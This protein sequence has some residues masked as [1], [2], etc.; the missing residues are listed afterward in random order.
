MA[1][2]NKAKFASKSR[3]SALRIEALEQRQLLAAVTGGGTEVGTDIRHPNGNIYDQVLM[4]G[5]SVTVSADAGQ[6]TRVSFLDLSGDIVQAEFSGKGSLTISLDQFKAAAEAANYNQPGVKYV[7]GL[8]TF[9]IQGEDASTNFSVFSVGSG[10]AVNQDLFAGGKTGGNHIADVARLLIVQDA[11]SPGG[12]SMGGIRAG[13]AIFAD[14]S[15]AVG[16][17]AANVHTQGPVI[18]GDVDASNAGVPTLKFGGNSQ[19]ATLQVAGGDLVQT[20]GQTFAGN[21]AGFTAINSTA[22]TDSSGTTLGSK[23]ISGSQGAGA[24]A[25]LGLNVVTLETLTTYDLTGKTQADLNAAFNGRTF[26]NDVTITG[27]LSGVNNIA[28]AEFRG[29]LTF[30]GVLTGNVTVTGAVKSLTLN[31][32]ASSSEV[33]K[34]G[35]IGN[36]TTAGTASLANTINANSIGDVTVGGALT[37]TVSTDTDTVAGFSGTESK[38]GNV[39]VTGN[40]NGTV[41]GVLGIGNVTV[42][43]EVN[44][45]GTT[46]QTSSGASGDAFLGSI[47]TI[48]INGDNRGGG[49]LINIIGNGTFGDVTIKGGGTDTAAHVTGSIT[50]GGKLG[51]DGTKTGNISVTDNTNATTTLTL[52]AISLT[53]TAANGSLGTISVTNTVGNAATSAIG[54]AGTGSI[55]DLTVTSS[56]AKSSTAAIGAITL[57][58]GTGGVT[59]SSLTVSNAETITIGAITGKNVGAIKATAVNV[60]GVAPSITLGA[61]TASNSNSATIGNITLDATTA[62]TSSVTIGG[63]IAT[64]NTASGASS[65]IGTVTI[66]GAAINI[67]N[68]LQAK[69]IGAVTLNGATVFAANKGF[70]ALGGLASLTVNGSTTFGTNVTVAT[71]TPNG[72]NA[73]FTGVDSATPNIWVGGTSG[74]FTFN[75]KTTFGAATGATGNVPTILGDNLGSARDVLGNLTFNGL[76]VGGTGIE[77]RAS[78]IGNVTVSSALN[79]GES[80]VTNFDVYAGNNQAGGLVGHISDTDPTRQLVPSTT[81]SQA[82]T[83]AR[84]GSNLANYSIGNITVSSTNTIGVTNTAL[85]SGSNTFAA[86]GKIG[87]VSLAGGGSAAVQTALFDSGTNGA[88]GALFQTGNGNVVATGANT[89]TLAKT[90]SGIDFDGNG[91]IGT[92]FASNTDTNINGS[93]ETASTFSTNVAVSI[94]N[95][96]VNAAALSGTNDSLWRAGGAASGTDGLVVLSAVKGA[97]YAPASLA[98]INSTLKGTVGNTTLTNLN[99]QL[100][101]R[102]TNGGPVKAADATTD[103][104]TSNLAGV[105]AAAGDAT[106]NSP[107]G[108]L[109][110]STVTSTLTASKNGFLVGGTQADPTLPAGATADG[111]SIIV[112]RL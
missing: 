97:N 88:P 29:A 111:N 76:V 71:S 100:S 61:V 91:V 43:G 106:T 108:T 99:Q 57:G 104:L 11:S 69:A 2:R 103:I 59:L 110:G 92:V 45:T 66:T 70:K 38:I 56:G 93:E 107:F 68:S 50:V 20:N 23:V 9:T 47:G 26:T 109:Q 105:I 102:P 1:K 18:I 55:G 19:F 58:T 33:F 82:E 112:I 31:S 35:T 36:V 5:A 62:T 17:S 12:S 64:N 53:S 8:A 77:V 73:A 44:T 46:L 94:G 63:N 49:K 30:T 3:K 101:I 89:N 54:F 87:N 51:A 96:S 22:G 21:L 84:D 40:L 75:G 27:D 7:G 86:I 65:S 81:A 85:F 98:V 78:S 48:T 60:G 10:N 90:S 14:I 39:A 52:G 13:N 41:Y 80:L 16:I 34:A 28:A 4:T 95:I 83:V 15:G 72:T 42:G 24:V 74:D 32:T 6:V 79:Q 37:G 25:G 67:N